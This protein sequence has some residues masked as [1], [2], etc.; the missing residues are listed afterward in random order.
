M[1]AGRIWLGRRTVRSVLILGGSLAVH[2]LVLMLLMSG[3]RLSTSVPDFPAVQLQI[4]GPSAPR[5]PA[6]PA[7]GS[8]GIGREQDQRTKPPMPDQ[9]L[10]GMP[11]GAGPVIALPAN[12]DG[13]GA[14]VQ[15][16]SLQPGLRRQLG[17]A[18]AAFLKLSQAELDACAQ[19]LAEG[20]ERA[21]RLA[22]VSP[23]KKAIFDTDCP[24]KDDWCLY[25]TG[26]GPYPGL[27][28]LLKK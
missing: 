15:G 24:P 3:L 9:Q 10:A 22:A 25:R 20:A 17:C 1:S 13:V 12:P 4:V 7:G 19:R 5:A 14:L 2:G 21:P 28:S 6:R 26:Q 8:P 16:P 18:N 27:F 23:E 11:I